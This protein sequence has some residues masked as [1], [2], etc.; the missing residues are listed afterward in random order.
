MNKKILLLT[1][2]ENLRNVRE[3]YHL[4]QPYGLSVISS[5]LKSKGYD[6]TL[7]DAAAHH[8]TRE[9]ILAYIQKMN[10]GILGLTLITNHLPQTL[11]FLRDVKEAL[12]NTITIVGGP[13]PTAEPESLLR[14]H[15][16]IDLVVLGEG[17]YTLLDVINRLRAGQSLDDTPGLC[18][19]VDGEIRINPKRE[20]IVDLDAMPFADWDSLPMEQYWYSW[21]VKKNYAGISLSRGCPYS[22]T[23]CGY[24]TLG[25]KFR[26]RS[27]ENI[28]EELKILYDRHHVR[29]LYFTDATI[30]FDN[31][32]LKEVCE[33]MIRMER[34]MLW[35]C[36]IRA[37]KVDVETTRLMKRAGCNRMFI[38]VESA[39]NHVLKLMRKAETIEK[40]REG[41]EKIHQ[42]GLYPDLGFIIG[43]PGDTEESIRKTIHF[44]QEFKKNLVVFT[45][46]TPFPGTSL[47][48]EIQQH[49]K[50]IDD[51]SKLDLYSIAYIPKGMTKKHIEELYELAVKSTYLRP[52]FIIAQLMRIRSWHDLRL[53]IRLALQLFM[54]RLK[55]FKR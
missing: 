18:L 20:P 7:L 2:P 15:N 34:P 9:Q 6:V 26:L 53:K 43:M 35:G 23:F 24:N 41:I 28:I 19:R 32:W 37:D 49:G 33:G 14:H 1:L 45:L 39:D 5:F 48:H 47:Y 22:C 16:Q 55:T 52:S 50:V 36:H 21:T 13:H 44:A 17:E 25:R 8:M 54:K 11:P 10:P 51:W 12:P 46:A 27:P 3:Y 31:D 30:N 38:G 40:I 42:V 29:N 4:L